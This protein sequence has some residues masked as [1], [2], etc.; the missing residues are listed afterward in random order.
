MSDPKASLQN[1]RSPVSRSKSPTAAGN[2]RSRRQ[3]TLKLQVRKAP[4]TCLSQDLKCQGARGSHPMLLDFMVVLSPKPTVPCAAWTNDLQGAPFNATPLGFP[5]MP[6]Y[7]EVQ[8]RSTGK[9]LSGPV[10][11]QLT[12][13]SSQAYR[14]TAQRADRVGRGLGSHS[15]HP[16]TEGQGKW[17]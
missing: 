6:P 13:Q 1:P 17:I 11:L 9:P 15:R 7:T 12:L 3:G 2:T 5:S 8:A 4:H 14:S 10:V 16:G